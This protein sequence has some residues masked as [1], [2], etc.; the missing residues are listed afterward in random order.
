ML[1]TSMGTGYNETTCACDGR[2]LSQRYTRSFTWTKTYKP[3]PRSVMAYCTWLQGLK[4]KQSHHQRV[5]NLAILWWI[6][7]MGIQRSADISNPGISQSCD[8]PREF[9]HQKQRKSQI[10]LWILFRFIRKTLKKQISLDYPNCDLLRLG[11]AIQ[12][13]TILNI[14]TK[15]PPHPHNTT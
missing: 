13:P 7:G 14:I 12:T 3:A 8:H 4:V 2:D 9:L 10:P 5:F 15:M 11:T 6:A 1:I